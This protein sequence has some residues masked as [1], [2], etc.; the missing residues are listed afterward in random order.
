MH[1]NVRIPVKTPVLK[2]LKLRLMRHLELYCLVLAMNLNKSIVQ[3][4]Y[5][6][7]SICIPIKTI[8]FLLALY[9]SLSLILCEHL[10]NGGHVGFFQI[11]HPMS[12]S[13]YYH[14]KSAGLIVHFLDINMSEF[15]SNIQIILVIIITVVIFII[16]KEVTV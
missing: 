6:P 10:E 13:S 5:S 15:L 16:P 9:N 4:L 3:Y 11:Y 2:Q 12:N 14:P 7:K 8:I 1:R